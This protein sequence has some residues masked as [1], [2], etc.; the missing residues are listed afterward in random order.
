MYADQVDKN[1][2][3]RKMHTEDSMGPHQVLL[4]L[5]PPKAYVVVVSPQRPFYSGELVT[6]WCD[7]VED[8]AWDLYYWYRDESQVPRISETITIRLPDEAASSKAT[9][10]V[11]SPKPP[12]Y[13]GEKVTL[14]CKIAKN[15]DWGQYYWHRNN[16]PVHRESKETITIT[17]PQEAAPPTAGVMVVSPQPPFFSGER[18][19]LRCN[20]VE[21][22][23]WGQYFWYRDNS[24]LPSQTSETITIT[25]PQEAGQYQ[26]FG[27]RKDRPC[28]SF[29]SERSH[30]GCKEEK[31]TPTISSE[32]DATVFTGNSVTLRC[33]MGKS[34]GWTFYWYRNTQTSDPVA[35]TDGD[36][37]SISPVKVSDG[38]QCWCRAGR[39]DPV[40]YTQYS[41][42]VWVKVIESPKAVLTLMS[43]W[44]TIFSGETLQL[45][46][47]IQEEQQQQ[48]KDWQYS[49]YKNGDDLNCMS[50]KP[51][52]TVVRAN[53]SH[54]GD[55]YCRGIRRGDLQSSDT[56]E[57][58]R[59]TVLEKT[60]PV[61]QGPPQTWLTE[62]DSVTL[63]C[64]VR[65]STTG[66][67]FHWYKTAPYRS[68]LS[69]VAGSEGYYIELLSDSIKGAGGSYTLSPSA[70]RDT[71]VYVCRAE[72]GEPAHHTEF[73]QPQPLWVT[74][75]SPSSSLV[76]SPNRNQHFTSESLSLSCEGSGNSTGWTLRGFSTR[77]AHTK[78]PP[79][80]TEVSVYWCQSDS[81]EQSSPVNITVYGG[82][83]ILESP[84]HPVTDGDP[85]TLRCRY[86]NQSSNISADFYKD[87]T[88]LQTSTTGEMTIPAVSKSHEGLF[89]CSNPE[90][91]ESPVSWITVKAPYSG[92]SLL[93][94]VGT[95]VRLVIIFAL[96]IMLL[97]LYLFKKLKGLSTRTTQTSL[98]PSSG[99][100]KG[101]TKQGS[102][103]NESEAAGSDGAQAEYIPMQRG[104]G[105]EYEE[106]A[107]VHPG[108]E[109]IPLQAD[110][111]QM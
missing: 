64:E 3:T 99:Q 78:C 67:R 77:I 88:L 46:C 83:V 17:L 29:L 19:T 11:L 87:G 36:S 22:T 104:N 23:D 98:P 91:G 66:W 49:W 65:G 30:I 103:Q 41:N 43:N 109:D 75:L 70:L 13:S 37:Y 20:I 73:S 110:P 47:N 71:G 102:N 28:V 45:Q 48:H 6:L 4:L 2:D 100:Q 44:S 33:D 8:T 57:V 59:I 60:K 5:T 79:C 89:Q 96:I 27:Q 85:L 53:K 1:P 62:G 76:V 105:E 12:L 82:D 21:Y 97:L 18:V 81:G 40:F 25:L 107:S 16:S 38:G 93:V 10:V 86:R 61:L 14:E 9:V 15:I 39:G 92:S 50:S 31:P 42:E 54:S 111:K 51:D 55:Y 56:S 26:C 80:W 63:S 94:T 24:L 74:G 52:Y 95:I 101:S 35:Q 69:Q 90:K 68:G 34:T 106:M 32:T 72:R 84:A 58:V 7:I 108:A